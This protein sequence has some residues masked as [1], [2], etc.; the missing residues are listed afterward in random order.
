MCWCRP[1][2]HWEPLRHAPEAA[3]FAARARVCGESREIPVGLVAAEWVVPVGLVGVVTVRLPVGAVGTSAVAAAAAV[4]AMALAESSPLLI[5]EHLSRHPYSFYTFSY[6]GKVF[7]SL[8]GDILYSSKKINPLPLR[9][10]VFF[11]RYCRKIPPFPQEE[12]SW[13]VIATSLPI[14]E[15][16]KLYWLH[17]YRSHRRLIVTPSRKFTWPHLAYCMLKLQN[18]YLHYIFHIMMSPNSHTAIANP[19]GPWLS[20]LDSKTPSF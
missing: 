20:H 15:A 12:R 3:R 17:H 13:Q 10:I 5:L 6:A 14:P 8:D 16:I 19:P 2:R 4:A 18:Y 7:W 1:H 9:G 11:H